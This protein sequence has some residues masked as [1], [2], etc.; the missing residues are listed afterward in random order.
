MY[1]IPANATRVLKIDPRNDTI[2]FIGPTFSRMKQ[3]WFGG[4]IGSDGCIYGI[5][6]NATGVLR[7]DPREQEVTVLGGIP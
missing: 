7:I 1:A 2:D 3:K 5:P 4:I 6:H